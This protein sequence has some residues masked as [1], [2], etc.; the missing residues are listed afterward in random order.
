[1]NPE[2]LNYNTSLGRIKD[3]YLI[4]TFWGGTKKAILQYYTLFWQTHDFLLAHGDFVGK[5]QNVM[6]TSYYSTNLHNTSIIIP[7]YMA[8]GCNQ[9]FY[10]YSYLGEVTQYVEGCAPYKT[11]NYKRQWKLS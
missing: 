3:A 5:D 4:G 6:A 2:L 9:W 7:S 1:M 10:F 8:K 11:T